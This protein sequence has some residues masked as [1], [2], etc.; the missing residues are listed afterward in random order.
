MREEIEKERRGQESILRDIKQNNASNPDN[1]YNN[2]N[3]LQYSGSNTNLKKNSAN[4]R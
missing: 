2:N 4:K 3:G 1:S